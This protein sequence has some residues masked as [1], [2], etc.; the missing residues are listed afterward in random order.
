MSQLCCVE[1]VKV[2]KNDWSFYPCLIVAHYVVG[3]TGD[4]IV[5]DLVL[6]GY[7]STNKNK[8]LMFCTNLRNCIIFS[9]T[10]TTLPH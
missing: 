3:D 2:R 1:E 4:I 7:L 9:E 10:C 6:D 5:S 8:Y